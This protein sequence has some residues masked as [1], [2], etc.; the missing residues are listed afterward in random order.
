LATGYVV[1]AILMTSL[2]TA[3]LPR[4]F[5]GFDPGPGRKQF[6]GLGPDIQWL[7]LTQFISEKSLSRA[8]GPVFDAVSFERIAGKQPSTL[9]MW[10]S[11]PI[12]YATRRESF[13]MGGVV[14][15]SSAPPGAPSGSP[16]PTQT[17]SGPRDVDF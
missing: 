5:M 1:V 14:S 15:S 6:F 12:R 11:F 4:S 3:P 10:S 2:H 9:Q 7:A 13:M 8:Q 17:P 16:P